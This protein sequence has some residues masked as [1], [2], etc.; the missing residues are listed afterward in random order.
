[1]STQSPSHKV[2][3][4][5]G[6]AGN[7]GLGRPKGVPNKLTANVKAAILAAFDAVG[8]SE[9]LAQQAIEN[10]QAFMTL[11][12]KVLPTQLSGDPE[13]PVTIRQIITGVPRAG[14][15]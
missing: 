1:M 6:R 15:R 13:N 2:G 12:G 7:R 5:T 11:L 8:G 4:S 3:A 10:P 14:D 9:Y